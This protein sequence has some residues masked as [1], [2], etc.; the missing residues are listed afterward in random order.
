MVGGYTSFAY[1]VYLLRIDGA[2]N[3]IWE[4]TL[5][6]LK[7]WG[8]QSIVSIGEGYFVVIGH[9]AQNDAYM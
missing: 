5:E 4:R 7:T 2:G 9:M 1:E 8:A 3:C 6:G